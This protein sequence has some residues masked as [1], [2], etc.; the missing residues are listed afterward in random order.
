MSYFFSAV[1]TTHNCH[2][3]IKKTLNS[4]IQQ[5]IDDF[6]IIIVDDNSSDNTI[7]V[8]REVLE[9]TN[10]IE[11]KIIRFYTN[12]GVS[13]ARNKGVSES[14]GQYIAFLDDDDIW[15]LDKLKIQKEIIMRK[16][17]DWIFSNYYVIN[18]HYK[19]IGRRRRETGMYD[20]KKI[21][22]NGNPIGMLTVTIKKDILIKFPFEKVHH[23]DY[24]L[25]LRLGKAGY[26]GYMCN[27]YLA[28]YMKSKD[29]IS[30]NKLSS[31]IWTYKVFRKNDKKFF[32]PF[33]LLLHYCLN[34]LTREK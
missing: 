15:L 33:K 28:C 32:E 30:S 1:I 17:L 27:G 16:K 5:T 29:S 18:D 13:V 12:Q 22:S 19:I 34:V 23:E 11:Y 3:T 10:N 31:I 9:K 2:A 7:D 20:Y 14:S 6:E 24:D 21:I 25:W 4:V 26:F 8:I